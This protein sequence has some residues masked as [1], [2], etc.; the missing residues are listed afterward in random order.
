MWVLPETVREENLVKGNAI[1]KCLPNQLV[2]RYDK[3]LCCILYSII[4]TQL[5][6]L[7]Y[8][9]LHILMGKHHFFKK[10]V[11]YIIE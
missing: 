11:G 6:N 4:N 9:I 3:Y 7:F 10:L 8:F 2:G 1:Q 5:I